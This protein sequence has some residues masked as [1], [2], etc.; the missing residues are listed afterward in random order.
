MQ[1]CAPDLTCFLF[2]DLALK[3]ERED[4]FVTVKKSFETLM[5]SWGKFLSD[6]FN[7]LARFSS[8]CGDR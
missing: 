4:E 6:W 8:I 7:P 5:M 3:K 1:S 2:F